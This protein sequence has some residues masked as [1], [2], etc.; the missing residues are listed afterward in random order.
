MRWLIY[1]WV[2][3]EALNSV[4][5]QDLLSWTRDAAPRLYGGNRKKSSE[6]FGSVR[7]ELVKRKKLVFSWMK[8]SSGGLEIGTRWPGRSM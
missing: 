6:D 3:K 5:K 7:G 1:F 8:Y 2:E 4:L